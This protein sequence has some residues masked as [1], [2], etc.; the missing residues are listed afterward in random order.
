PPAQKPPPF[1]LVEPEQPPVVTPAI[2]VEPIQ[3]TVVVEPKAPAP[4][5]GPQ[6]PSLTLE[7]L[8][9][10]AAEVG[11]ALTYEIVVRNVGAVPAL[12]VRVGDELRSGTKVLSGSPNPALEGNRLVWN[13]EKLDPDGESRFKVEVEPGSSG[14][15]VARAEVIVSLA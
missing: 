12:Q 1:R 5:T 13:L 15:F 6:T 10:R 3:R 8:I 14:E 4:F 2:K 11:K 9:P 7:K